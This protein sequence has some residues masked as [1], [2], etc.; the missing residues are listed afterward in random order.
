MTRI[1]KLG[2][3]PLIAALVVLFG[4]SGTAKAQTTF[5]T[6]VWGGSIAHPFND[7]HAAHEGWYH[8]GI[9]YWGPNKQSTYI[10][11]SNVGVVSAV[12]TNG[13]NDHG[14]GNCVIIRHNVVISSNGATCPYYT[15]YAHLDS[16]VG[17]NQ[18]GQAVNRGQIIG[19]M[20]STGSGL[21]YKWG[22]T[23]YCSARFLLTS[24][25]PRF[26]G[27]RWFRA[28]IAPWK[29]TSVHYPQG[30]PGTEN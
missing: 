15:L 21:R 2:G 14:L 12:I 22:T 25:H 7:T 30:R 8:T 23:Q 29:Q 28:G 24:F 16:I 20:G 1:F 27:S 10:L 4:W 11:A 19:I 17:I 9:D 13:N 5:Q 26:P 18:C 3:L 6:P